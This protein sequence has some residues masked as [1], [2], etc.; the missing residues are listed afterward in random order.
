MEEVWAKIL[1]IKGGLFVIW[2]YLVRSLV[3]DFFSFIF[4]YGLVKRELHWKRVYVGFYDI[5]KAHK[6]PEHCGREGKVFGIPSGLRY[7]KRS[8]RPEHHRA[9]GKAF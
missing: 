8:R 3:K 5:P 6:R 4:H 2:A 1:H 7:P 9:L